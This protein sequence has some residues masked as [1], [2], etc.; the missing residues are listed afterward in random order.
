MNTVSVIIPAYNSVSFLA[1]CLDSVDAEGVETIV[2]DD[3]STD[4]TAEMVRSRFPDVRLFCQENRGVSSAR[5]SGL[6]QAAG[7]YV[8]F[9]D[10]DDRL[11]KGALR[12]LCDMLA[13]RMDEDVVIMRS[14]TSD[15]E[16]YPWAGRFDSGRTYTKADMIRLGY[17]RGSVCGCAFRREYVQ[18]NHLRFPE[19]IAMGEDLI[20]LSSALSLG[21]RVA[22]QDIAF[23]EIVQRADSASRSLS[24]DFMDR[25]A[26]GLVAASRLVGDPA[27]RT[28]AC[29]SMMLGITRVGR[30]LGY[31]P[32]K[33]FR[34]GRFA[35]VLPLRSE[36][37]REN[38][39]MV[40]MM[41]CAYPLLFFAQQVKDS[42]VR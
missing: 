41:N 5:N 20:F 39:W 32:Q 21:G 28:Q 24:P 31:G 27:L 6:D 4:G 17:V 19:G 33:T 11:Y 30:K 16:H 8:V 12:T 35:E 42:L 7:R 23:Y 2:V 26:A 29:L 36:G 13:D 34:K 3:G 40:A 14:F 15:G 9:L 37:L 18:Q 10:A 38:R 25:Y 22:F 1:D